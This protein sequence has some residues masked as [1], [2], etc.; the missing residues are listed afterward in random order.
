MSCSAHPAEPGMRQL[1]LLCRP[2]SRR[3]HH[4]A[5]LPTKCHP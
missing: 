2:P 5:R 1:R 4:P 3:R